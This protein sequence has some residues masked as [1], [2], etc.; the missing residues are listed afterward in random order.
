MR[1]LS[2]G[3][4][5][6]TFMTPFR[7]HHRGLPPPPSPVVC[8]LCF[9]WS[10]WPLSPPPPP[11]GMPRGPCP[12]R[13]APAVPPERDHV[14][15]DQRRLDHGQAAIP[16]PPDGEDLLST[17]CNACVFGLPHSRSSSG[18]ASSLIS[19]LKPSLLSPPQR[20]NEEG[21]CAPPSQRFKR[22]EHPLAFEGQIPMAP[23]SG[24]LQAAV[25]GLHGPRR[26][27]RR[28]PPQSPRG[29]TPF[30]SRSYHPP[31]V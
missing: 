28:P 24:V 29:R 22:R 23:G 4:V 25:G 17:N 5:C 31:N 15:P 21:Q 2:A 12:T 16:L 14:R 11:R 10:R 18:D 1:M 27:R 7:P 9:P 13:R 6:V 30:P 8:P 20:Q 26:L 3:F 19:C